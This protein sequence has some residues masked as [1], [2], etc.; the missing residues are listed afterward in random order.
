V[1][2]PVRSLSGAYLPACRAKHALW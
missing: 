1:D 2:T